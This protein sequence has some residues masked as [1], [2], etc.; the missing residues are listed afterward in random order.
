MKQ[1]RIVQ[2]VL[3]FTTI[4]MAGTLQATPAPDGVFYLKAKHSNKCVHQ[5]QRCSASHCIASSW[6]TPEGA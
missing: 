6:L 5:L 3:L 1:L 4:G 2:F